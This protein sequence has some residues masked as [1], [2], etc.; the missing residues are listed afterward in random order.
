M[1]SERRI[2]R[3]RNDV[4]LIE[5]NIYILTPDLRIET[6]YLVT[7]RRT[8]EGTHLSSLASACKE[9][10]REVVESKAHPATWRSVR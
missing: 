6:V 2:I 10:E 5:E 8:P 1:A 7:S 9:F 4:A 3:T